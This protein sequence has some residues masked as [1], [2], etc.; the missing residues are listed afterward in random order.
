MLYI[1]ERR[2][3]NIIYNRKKKMIKKVE[4]MI[5]REE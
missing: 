1:I 4:K 2:K 5:E 3:R